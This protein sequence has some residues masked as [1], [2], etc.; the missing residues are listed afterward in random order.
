MT[1]SRKKKCRRM[2][3]FS[4]GKRWRLNNFYQSSTPNAKE[5]WFSFC[6]CVW[7]QAIFII[8]LEIRL[9]YELQWFTVTRNTNGRLLQFNSKGEIAERFHTVIIHGC[10]D[11]KSTP[12]SMLLSKYN[13]I[14]IVT[15]IM[16][17]IAEAKRFS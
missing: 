10:G 12:L 7:R 4:V 1:K 3:E 9:T 5:I 6:V 2:T 13:P 17:W 11:Y 16:D 15:V 14:T 8:R